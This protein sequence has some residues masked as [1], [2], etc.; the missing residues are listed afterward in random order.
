M[1]QDFLREDINSKLALYFPNVKVEDLIVTGYPN[2][3]QVVVTLK[4]SIIN[5]SISD[6]LEIQL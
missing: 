3:N 4:Y 2:N 5:T 1:G 6:T